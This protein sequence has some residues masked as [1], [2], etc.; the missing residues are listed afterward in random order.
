V[1]K[2]V[3]HWTVGNLDLTQV[4]Q[5]PQALD[6]GNVHGKDVDQDSDRYM[7]PVVDIRA[8]GPKGS[9]GCGASCAASYISL[10][11]LIVHDGQWNGIYVGAGYANPDAGVSGHVDHLTI[12]DVEARGNAGAGVDTT[13]TFEKNTDY[14]LTT[15]RVLDSYLHDNGGDGLVM[16]QVENGLIQGNH[17][18]YNGRIRNARVGCWAWDSKDVTIQYN[19]ADHNMTPLADKTASDGGGLDLDMGTVDSTMQYNWSHDN[20]GEGYLVAGQPLAGYQCC[21]TTDATVRYNV[22]ER[23]GSKNGGGITLFGESSRTSVYNNTVYYVP[24]RTA[25]TQMLSGTGGDL[26]SF[27][28][29]NS[30][31][32]SSDVANNVFITDGTDN[33]T[34]DDTNFWSDGRGTL[35]FDR[36]LW[37]RVEGGLQFHLG[38]LSVNSWG[39]WRALGKDAH[40]ENADPKVTGPLG[41]GPIA[42]QLRPGSPA[43]DAAARIPGA[44]TGMATSDYFGRS[45]RGA[46]YDIG[47]AEL[48]GECAT[49]QS[50]ASPFAQGRVI[51]SVHVTSLSGSKEPGGGTA[52]ITR[53]SVVSWQATVVDEN[54]SPA[55]GVTVYT[56]VYKPSWDS[57]YIAAQAPT[58][59]TGR[60]VFSHLSAVTDPAG[61]YFISL[62]DVVPGSMSVDYDSSQNAAW[63]STVF[64][65]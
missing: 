38:K 37:Y 64:L 22:S 63:T 32:P 10:E 36:N 39:D 35:H 21:V 29:A 27:T 55:P 13:G 33:P 61:A 62:S 12:R 28:Y 16:G 5:K 1:L 44:P 47:S 49:R 19:E 23:D 3:S 59:S 60:A 26:T 50:N 52:T 7:K 31:S 34:S 46:R 54:G 4:G 48:T 2:N 6:A 53:G 11:N 15:V 57:T 56:V 17:C 20:E 43:I 25:D 42:Y 51:P 9:R 45:A 24:S 18:A 40:G 14:E 41:G 65:R 30:G 8:L 58:D